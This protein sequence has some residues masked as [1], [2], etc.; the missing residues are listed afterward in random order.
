MTTKYTTKKFYNKW[1]YKIT[2][3]IPGISYCRYHLNDKKI[4]QFLDDILPTRYQNLSTSKVEKNKSLIKQFCQHLENYEK[5]QYSL[6]TE[7]DRIDVYCNDKEIYDKLFNEFSDIVIHKFEPLGNPEKLLESTNNKILASRYPHNK[8]HYKVFLQPHKMEFD[9]ALRSK[10]INWLSAN[11]SIRISDSVKA[12]FLVTNWNWDRRYMLI[13]DSQTL[14]M[15][16]LK[17]PDVIGRIYEYEIVD[18]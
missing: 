15:V 4:Y 16:K 12:W 14:L 17:N 11:E 18:K 5:C 7:R 10:Y 3:L 9:P 8:Y 1:I 2:V 13:A 6:R